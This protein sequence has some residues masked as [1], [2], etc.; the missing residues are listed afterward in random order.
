M[1]SG[2]LSARLRAAEANLAAE[3]NRTTFEWRD[4]VAVRFAMEYWQPL[5]RTI[6]QY[7]EAV[8]NLE[9]CLT[10]ADKEQHF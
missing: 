1:N 2:P 10:M 4:Q 8:E 7:L 5:E 6:R 9:K 3:W